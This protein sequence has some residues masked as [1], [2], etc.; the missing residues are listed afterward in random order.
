MDWTNFLFSFRGRLA[1]GKYWLAG[2]LYVALWL[3]F[4]VIGLLLLGDRADDLLSFA[5]VGLLLWLVGVVL[6]AVT[7]WSGLAV[8][9][10][11]LHDRNKTGWWIVL[12][13]FAPSMLSGAQA[14]GSGGGAMLLM[15]VGFAVS[16]WSFIEL[17][18]LRGTRG[19][20][21]YGPD[22]LGSLSN[23]PLR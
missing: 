1:R 21:R 4:F 2:F 5:G 7:C 16:V 22:P 6:F 17:A 8:G 12:F 18:C 20:N 19:P 23:E 11:R 15:L 3:A 10:K 14:S 13:Y 9:V